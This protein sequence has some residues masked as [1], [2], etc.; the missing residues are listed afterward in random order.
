[1]LNDEECAVLAKP[2]VEKWDGLLNQMERFR[3]TTLEGLAARALALAQH[4]G[5]K[6][7]TGHYPFAFQPDDADDVT[8]RLL[9]MLLSDAV[10]MCGT[11]RPSPDAALLALRP[12]FDRLHALMV[13]YNLDLIPDGGNECA[14][15]D[16][17]CERIA[18]ASPAITSTGR[19]FQAAAAMHHLYY[20]LNDDQQARNP[21][22]LM[23]KG[24]A[25]DAYRSVEAR[26]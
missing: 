12:E 3:A 9:H 18:T 24:L 14:D 21:A 23:L 25:G 20:R 5:I 26:S 4:S 8:G 2:I 6:P 7:G 10:Q 17:L 22:W 11:P 1:M 19:A 13:A 16:S 15:F